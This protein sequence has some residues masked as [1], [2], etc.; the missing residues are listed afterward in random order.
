MILYNRQDDILCGRG[1]F[2]VEHGQFNEFVMIVNAITQYLLTGK[3]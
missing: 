2:T 1:S 3:F